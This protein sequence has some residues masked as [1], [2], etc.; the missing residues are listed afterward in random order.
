MVY[1]KL[2]LP[3]IGELMYRYLSHL[4]HSARVNQVT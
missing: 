1:L 3:D 2:G 4:T